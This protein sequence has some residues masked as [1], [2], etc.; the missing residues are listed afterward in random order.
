MIIWLRNLAALRKSKIWKLKNYP[1]GWFAGHCSYYMY[2]HT[3]IHLCTN[4]HIAFFCWS[5][6]EHGMIYWLLSCYQMGTTL[7]ITHQ[8]HPHIHTTCTNTPVLGRGLEGAWCWWLTERHSWAASRTAQRAL[9]WCEGGR[10]WRESSTLP[11]SE[12][13]TP[14]THSTLQGTIHGMED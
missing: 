11:A 5:T 8:P 3:Y 4:M 10:Q 14:R 9:R 12:G 2:I 13:L 7:E 1:Q 6:R